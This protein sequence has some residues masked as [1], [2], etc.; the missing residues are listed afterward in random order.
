MLFVF[1]G[2]M[3]VEDDING[4][5]HRVLFT[6]AAA[7]SD[8]PLLPCLFIFDDDNEP[9]PLSVDWVPLELGFGTSQ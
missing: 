9:G 2:P 4:V 3:E 1:G 6:A 5:P 8:S 7:L